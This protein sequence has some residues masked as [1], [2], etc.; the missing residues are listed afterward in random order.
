M[1]THHIIRIGVLAAILIALAPAAARADGFINP[2]IGSNFASDSACSNAP[3]CQQKH[4]TFGASFGVMGRVL[5]F[6]EDVSFSDQFF[7]DIPNLES[8]AVSLM[9]NLLFIPQIGPVHP[10]GTVGVGLVLTR[11]TLTAPAMLVS[12][13]NSLGIDFGGGVAI[14]FAPHVG[15]RGDFRVFRTLQDLSVLG[16]TLPNTKLQYGR[17]A[18][19]VIFKF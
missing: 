16:F 11:A 17:I 7:G 19:G 15:V 12:D 14:F 13:N 1:T 4:G 5:G 18:G 6:E 3:N 9:S 10:Y 2:Y 8:S